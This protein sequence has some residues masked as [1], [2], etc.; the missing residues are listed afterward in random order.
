MDAASYQNGGRIAFGP[1]GMP[2]VTVGDAGNSQAAQDRGSL[3]GKILRMT[4]DGDVPN[5]NPF[6]SSLVYSFGHRNPQG[7]AWSEGGTMYA[8]EF[9]QDTCRP[10][11]RS[12]RASR[13]V[14]SSTRPTTRS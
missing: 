11:V 1:D 12:R 4:P 8:S 9:G 14:S 10:G 7:L 5:D 3:S 2:Y 6:E 13:T